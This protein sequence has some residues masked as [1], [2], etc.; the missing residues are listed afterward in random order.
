[1]P[2]PMGPHGDGRHS[3]GLFPPPHRQIEASGIG[4]GVG[5]GPGVFVVLIDPLGGLLLLLRLV[6]G[7][8]LLAGGGVGDGGAELPSLIHW[9]KEDGTVQQLD[10]L[11]GDGGEDL[12]SPFRLLKLL[13][14]LQQHL[15]AV[16][17]L[18]R[19]AGLVF[20]P[21]GQGAGDKTG[22]EHDQKVT[23]YPA[24]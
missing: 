12:T 3:Q 18:H 15:G 22:G 19:H 20:D 8:I 10:Q 23:G 24:S 14:G 6:G 2:Q 7:I 21:H 5:S 11:A 13:A 1:M 9:V 17:L 4:E 16:G